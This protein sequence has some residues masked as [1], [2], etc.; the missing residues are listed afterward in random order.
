MTTATIIETADQGAW[1]LAAFT[2]ALRGED[3]ALATAAQDLV[4]A[5]GCA[6]L[7]PEGA[8]R[9]QLAAQT[10]ASLLQTAALVGGGAVSW[11]DQTDDALVAQGHASAQGARAFAEFVLP[12]LGD[13]GRRLGEPGA[14]ILDVGTGVGALAI[15]Y[16]RQFPAAHVVG[17]DVSE[18]ALALAATTVRASQA[19]DRIELRRQ[20]V[21]EF[22]DVDGF[23]IAW[24]P[25]PFIPPSVLTAGVTRVAA[26]LRPGGWL[27][28]GHGKY[29]T[30][31]ATNALNRF[32]TVAFGGTPLDDPQAARLV[33]GAGLTSVVHA[34]TPPGAPAITLAR[35]T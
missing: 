18:R 2:L 10:A 4:R 35:K 17:I 26:S 29:G 20:D 9:D 3:G 24:V 1:Q 7:G 13:L 19:A 5:L 34:P 16:A 31:P 12:K 15:A 6:D 11:S 32:K 8:P 23:D 27:M 14:R 33:A 22:A 28:I 21:A 30:D 25:A